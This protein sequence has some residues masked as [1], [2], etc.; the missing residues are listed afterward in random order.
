MPYKDPRNPKYLDSRSK[1]RKDKR[2]TDDEWRLEQNDKCKEWYYN[3][4]ERVKKYRKSDKG[5]K[6]R[7]IAHWKAYP[8]KLNCD[9][10]T[11]DMLYDYYLSKNNC[12]LCETKFYLEGRKNNKNLD[13]NHTTKQFRWVVC[14]KCN[15]KIGRTDKNFIYLMKELKLLFNPKPVFK[16]IEY[17]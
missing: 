11:W 5:I 6:I 12:E 7:H 4:Q 17:K 2:Q 9:Y 16:K 15:N 1:Q 3:N 13:H 10:P 14:S 8:V